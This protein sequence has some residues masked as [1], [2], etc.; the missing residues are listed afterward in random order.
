MDSEPLFFSTMKKGVAALFVLGLL[1]YALLLALY[2]VNPSWSPD[3]MRNTSKAQ[4]V[5]GLP[6]SGITAFAIVCV[7]ERIAPPKAAED[8]KLSFKAFGLEFSGP[9]GPITLW[10][11]CY[12]ALVAS[13]RIVA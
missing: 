2:A 8:G 9:A 3:F 11:V 7:L 5:F 6:L 10:V 4:Y 1:V 13:M 12:L